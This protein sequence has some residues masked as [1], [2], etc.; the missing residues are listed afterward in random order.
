MASSSRYNVLRAPRIAFGHSAGERCGVAKRG[1]ESSSGWTGSPR[2]CGEC[3]EDKRRTLAPDSARTA[4]R[5]ARTPSMPAARPNRVMRGRVS[6]LSISSSKAP[7]IA[8][9]PPAVGRSAGCGTWEFTRHL[10]PEALSGGKLNK[11]N[12]GDVG[13]RPG[14]ADVLPKSLVRNEFLT[15]VGKFLLTNFV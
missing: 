8:A 7:S 2:T 6:P 9:Q 15:E 4:W 11:A 3:P 5:A 10:G 12:Q 1:S 14:K 13:H